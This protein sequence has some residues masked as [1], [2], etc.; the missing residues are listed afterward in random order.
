MANLGGIIKTMRNYMRNDRGINGD[1]QR[2]E[3]LGWMLFL[4]IFDSREEVLELEEDDY[5]SPI[6]ERF[7]WKNWAADPEGMTGDELLEFVENELFPAL[8]AAPAPAKNDR[9]AFLIQET[10]LGNNNYMKSGTVMRQVL[11]KINEID[12]N[13]SDDKHVFGDI[14]EGLLKELQSAGKSGEFYTP[15]G[16]TQ[17]MCD[18]IAPQLGETVL[19]P[20]CG[21]GGFL[22]AA[23]EA[24]KKQR[25]N[26]NDI[27]TI[28]DSV[29]GFEVKPLPL[30]L[31]AVNL[32]A[33]EID[34]PNVAVQDTLSRE[35]TAIKRREQVDI[36][37]ANPPFGGVMPHAP[38]VPATYKTR[39][40]AD[41]FL[42]YIMRYLK[43]GGRAAIVLPDGSLT[44]EGV[45]ARIR[46]KWL[47]D[48]NLHTIV[49]LP[50][51]VF[52][53]YATVATNLLFFTKGE[54]TK[55]IW[56]YEHQL[57]KGQKSY[58]KTKPIQVKEFD[59]IKKWWKQRVENE[60]AWKV[61]ISE[62][63]KNGWDLDV[64]NEHAQQVEELPSS[65][66]IL[67]KLDNSFSKSL[68]LLEDIKAALNS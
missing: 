5:Q 23:V 63:K 49:R 29:R 13:S 31:C 12:F 67:E 44:G 66:A 3:Q 50:N 24:M 19:D 25:N 55:E 51:S 61:N 57:P 28:A 40:T 1:A 48:C 54:P 7:K 9:M 21:T 56:Y 52:K 34:N 39:E 62:I 46:E 35:L 42:L 26:I 6:P 30:T 33:H 27:E 17:F 60:V 65:E 59:P 38:N 68:Q 64:K 20:A 2:L 8:Q 10:F 16:V 32:L 4:K 58:S 11:N 41:L 53:P 37:L 43:D 45:K 22:T 18:I 47:T 15:R 14:Y 36:I